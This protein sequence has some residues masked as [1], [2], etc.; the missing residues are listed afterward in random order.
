[1]KSAL[2][3]R[4]AVLLA[5][6]L[7]SVGGVVT[8]L[9]HLVSGPK[10]EPT[11]A[12]LSTEAGTKAYPAF[13]PDGQRIAYSA[14]GSAKVDPFHIYVR[15]VTTDTPRALT[16]GEGNDVSPAWSPDGNQLAFLRLID[17]KAQYMVVPMGGGAE[18]KVAEFPSSGDESQ[19][20]PSVSWTGDGKSLIVVNSSLTPPALAS[21][22]VD[23]G[24][25]KAVSNP[26]NAEGDFVP[27]VSPDGTTLAFVR[28]SGS[29]GADVFLSDPRGGS[30]RRLTF[31]DRPIRGLSWT[32]DG[33]E[34]V[35]SGNRFG[36]GWRLWRLPIH[37]G[38]PQVVAIAGR[39]SQYPAVARAG[40][41][42]AYSD[43]PSV[44]AIWRASMQLEGQNDERAVL[45]SSGR[46]SWPAY[47]P[48]GKRIANISDQTGNDEVWVSDADG[49]NRFQ[50][51]KFNG[52]R[53]G[54]VRWSP[55]GK[56]VIFTGS[57]ETGP[58]L[59]TME[60]RAG[61]TP[62]RLVAGASNG[63]WSRDGKW[64]YFDMRQQAWRATAEGGSPEPVSKQRNAAQP[65]ESFDGKRVFFRWRRTIW[66]VPVTGGEAE[67]TIVPEHDMLW[68]T[69]YPAKNG[70]YYLEWE[71]SSRGTVVAFY[72]FATKKSSVVFRMRNGEMAGNSSFSISPDG[73]YI[74]YP[75]VDQSE[76]NLMLVEN[77]R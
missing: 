10:I 28:N 26:E 57:S 34:L 7:C 40:N 35:Y 23:T 39:Q 13:S 49:S 62:A 42:M 15:T 31:D 51:T 20:L 74:L 21:V 58:D 44:S 17:G 48:D 46:E 3:R 52:L 16:N 56:K 30:A 22:A 24:E 8:L 14:R 50:L 36:G 72:D 9:G 45:R 60:A 66:S 63:S 43:S 29:E 37:G 25:V 41:R 70:V 73:K 69:I 12:A 11:K 68:T 32:P 18:R 64:I 76:T 38:S 59:Y 65:V 71:R 33:R 1:M 47:S 27:T 77:F 19:P 75:R 54:R 4:P 2:M 5:L 53:L 6:A 61:V 55:D 67:E